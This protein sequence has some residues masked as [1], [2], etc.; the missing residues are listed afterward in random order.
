[1]YQACRQIAHFYDLLGNPSKAREWNLQ[2]ELLRQRMNALCWNGRFYSHFVPEDPVPGHINMDPVQAISLSNTYSMNRGTATPEMAQ[3]I[4]TRYKEVA[5]ETKAFSKASWYGVYPFISPQ[6]GRYKVDEYMNGAILPLVGGELVKAAF[7]NGEEE[8]AVEQL[9]LMD[10]LM[11]KNGRYLPGCINWDGTAQKEAIPAEWGQAAFVS[12]LVEGLA[13]VVDKSSLFRTVE[14]SPRWYFAGVRQTNVTVGYGG[15]GNQVK[16]DYRYDDKKRLV[17]M[18]LQ[19]KYER[20]T[21]RIPIP[22]GSSRASGSINGKAVK[23]GMEKV[24]R[25]LYAVVEGNDGTQQIEVKFY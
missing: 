15:D 17:S 1:M 16:Y 14:I 6:F 23:V 20:Y 4:I 25:S 5:A 3:Q 22:E 12:A 9:H 8:Y 19:G 18:Q 13:G 24:N 11:D 21:L 7:Q 2:A 10:S